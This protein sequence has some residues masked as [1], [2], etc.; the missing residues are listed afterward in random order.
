MQAAGEY[1]YVA[2]GSA[3]FSLSSSLTTFYVIHYH[4][5]TAEYRVACDDV[6]GDKTYGSIGFWRMR[7][8]IRFKRYLLHDAEN[9]M[10]ETGLDGQALSVR[11]MS[12]PD[13]DAR[14]QQE[15]P[16]EQMSFRRLLLGKATLLGNSFK[17]TCYPSAARVVEKV[18]Q[19]VKDNGV[20]RVYF[21][22]DMSEDEFNGLT[23]QI[24]AQCVRR[25]PTNDGPADTAVDMLVASKTKYYVSNRYDLGASLITE[26]FLLEND[27]RTSN[28]AVW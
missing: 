20:D 15:R 5:T 19:F 13:C 8:R 24:T 9:F 1:P 21:S 14:T 12:N 11:L 25:P 7:S 18:N 23:P 10:S 2:G 16:T 22:T 17:E 6:R 28:I 3:S 27:L 4:Y 26:F